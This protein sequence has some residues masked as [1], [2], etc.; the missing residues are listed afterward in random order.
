MKKNNDNKAVQKC[1]KVNYFLSLQIFY[2][3]RLVNNTSC[4][5]NVATKA[6]V[7]LPTYTLGMYVDGKW[8]N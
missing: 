8:L 2:H 6:I 4:H 3:F 1:G 7:R 5:F